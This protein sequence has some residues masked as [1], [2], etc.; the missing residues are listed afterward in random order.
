[1]H[2]FPFVPFIVGGKKQPATL[3]SKDLCNTNL[4]TMAF[5]NTAL[6][7]VHAH[8]TSGVY[9][10]IPGKTVETDLLF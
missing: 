5:M 6:E 10:T 9:C 7:A 8:D 1:M 3:T 4:V 2:T